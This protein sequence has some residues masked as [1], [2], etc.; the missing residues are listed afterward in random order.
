MMSS[1]I[2]KKNMF[3]ILVLQFVVIVRVQEMIAH[4]TKGMEKVII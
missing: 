3:G 2:P 1:R 4:T